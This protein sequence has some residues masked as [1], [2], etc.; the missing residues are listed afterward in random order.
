MLAASTMQDGGVDYYKRQVVM[1]K[2]VY[3]TAAEK[4]VA[5]EVYEMREEGRKGGSMR[6]LPAWLP[7]RRS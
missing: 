3:A 6:P 1:R 4:N 2:V 5:V 7:R